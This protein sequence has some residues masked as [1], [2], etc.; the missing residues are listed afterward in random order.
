MQNTCNWLI[1]FFWP[2]HIEKMN[3]MCRKLHFSVRSKKLK[4]KDIV[5]Q[6]INEQMLNEI[7]Q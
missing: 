5:L 3:A 6:S 1:Y 2:L 4:V 7:T